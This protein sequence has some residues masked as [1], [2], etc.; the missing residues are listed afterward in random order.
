[1][2]VFDLLKVF[3]RIT[4]FAPSLLTLLYESSRCNLNMKRW[5]G[6][7]FLFP[8]LSR[9]PTSIL[10]TSIKEKPR[11]TWRRGRDSNPRYLAAR[12]FSRLFD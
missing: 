6:E 9:F 4:L 5:Q 3:Y 8:R 7:D 10:L 2:R 11:L 1:M 12:Q